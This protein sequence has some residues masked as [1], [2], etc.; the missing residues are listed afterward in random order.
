MHV[1]ANARIKESI[2]IACVRP[3][4]NAF[5]HFRNE[6]YIFN[7]HTL[8]ACVFVYMH[9]YICVCMYVCVYMYIYIYIYIYILC[10]ECL[11]VC[12]HILVTFGT[13]GHT[14]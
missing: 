1:L 5:A 9:V 10:M 14:Y 2:H 11:F 12:R 6:P 8:I 3:T 4:G 13:H 7:T